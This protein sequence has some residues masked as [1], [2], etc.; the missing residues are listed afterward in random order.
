MFENNNFII[1]NK[2]SSI[3]SQGGSKITISIDDI[4]KNISDNYKLVHRL[5]K[6]TS[7]LLII[8]K[9]LNSAKIFGNLFKSQD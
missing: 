5:D 9:N 8:A 6:E 7:G 2:W 3:S 4:I 1:F